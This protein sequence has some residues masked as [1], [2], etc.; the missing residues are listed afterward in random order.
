VSKTPAPKA[1][2]AAT[3]PRHPGPKQVRAAQTRAQ[4]L[5]A[6]AKL[7]A[8]RGFSHT[9]IADVADRVGMT[10][11]A[12]YFHFRDKE[13]IGAEVV[14]E[15]YVRWRLRVEEARSQGLQPL[16]TVRALL[17]LCAHRFFDDDVVKAGARLQAERSLTDTTLPESY[18]EW[19]STI[20]TMLAQAHGAGQ[21]R[22]GIDPE[23]AAHA[24][25]SAFFGA[26]QISDVLNRRADLAR[27]WADLSDLLFASIAADPA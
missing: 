17:D 8:D 5:A 12:V 18:V 26:Q 2:H 22:E 25:V 6:A 24:L 21:L 10:K 15:L 9:S 27:R 11:G 4:V 16:E 1:S 7:F 19:I 13:D 14:R 23:A 3:R 20:S